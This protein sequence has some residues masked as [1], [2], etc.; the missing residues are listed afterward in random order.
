MT[1]RS[2]GISG[3]EVAALFRM[4][5]YLTKMGLYA[6]KKGLV[7]EPE[8]TP[9]MRLGKML[10][11]VVV[12]LFEEE[13]G[14][15]VE[16]FDKLIEHPKEPLIIGTPDGGV[17]EIAGKYEGVEWRTDL[18]AGFEAKTAGLDRAFE[19]GDEGTDSIP[20]QYLFQTQHYM[21]LTGLKE[22][23]LAALIGGNDFRR[24][25]LKADEELQAM[26]LQEIRKFWHD[27]IERD[28]APEIDASEESKQYLL[29]LYPSP[30]EGVREATEGENDIIVGLLQTQKELRFLEERKQ[31][32][33]HQLQ[34][35][36]GFA[37]GI[38]SQ[39]GKANWTTTEETVV[40]SFVRKASRTL[41]VYGK[42]G[43]SE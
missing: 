17:N 20:Q 24:F 37:K 29:R 42:K 27:H 3:T 31:L 7:P 43:E 2:Q 15:H 36:I 23:H 4:S 35:S 38:T 6:R 40:Q 11:P 12:K 14:K 13:T 21:M 16:W 9:R 39:Y 8:Q 10:E 18:E 5:P 19:W 30:T 28:Q 32:L 22:W 26:M 33:R 41:R 25:H 34:Q 1:V